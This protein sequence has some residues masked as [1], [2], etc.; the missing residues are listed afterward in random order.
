MTYCSSPLQRRLQS[1]PFPAAILNP[2]SQKNRHAKRAAAQDLTESRKKLAS[3]AYDLFQIILPPP[4]QNGERC[5]REVEMMAIDSATDPSRISR[6]T[7]HKSTYEVSQDTGL[8]SELCKYA[9]LPRGSEAESDSR[10]SVR[11]FDVGL[12]E[13]RF[14]PRAF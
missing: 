7:E 13:G 1:S 12:I 14:R 11:H 4:N 2:I 3:S 8:P 5:N 6:R 10:G 9:E